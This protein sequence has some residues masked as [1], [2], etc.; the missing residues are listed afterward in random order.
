MNAKDTQEMSLGK[1]LQEL[2]K[3]LWSIIGFGFAGFLIA[4][5]ISL[6]FLT[7]KYSSTVDLLVNQK[8]NDS[9]VQFNLQ[10][11]DLQAINTYKD[12]LKKPV[13]LKPVLRE[14]KQRDNYSGTIDDLTSAV[15]I[16]NATNSKVISVTVKDKNSYVAANLANSIARVFTKKIKEIMKINNVVVVSKGTVHNKPVFPNKKLS[17]LLGFFMGI[18]IGIVIV[19]IRLTFDKT[20]KDNNYL[21]DE[22]GVITLGKVYHIAKNENDFQVVQII[23]NSEKEYN[24]I[25]KRRRV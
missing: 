4:L 3:H 25:S 10:Q 23:S 14:A 20:V 6:F 13:I 15:Q 22:L 21:A 2:K 8:S 1:L 5:I 11:A 7:P 19:L 12:V 18:F 24:T 17:A 9:A 16:N